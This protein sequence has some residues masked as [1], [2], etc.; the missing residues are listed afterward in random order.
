MNDLQ[1]QDLNARFMKDN[2]FKQLVAN[3]RSRGSLESL[4]FCALVNGRIEI[5]SGHHRVRA[6]KEA[7]LTDIHILLDESGLTRSQVAAKQIAHNA[8]SGQDD[9]GILR[10]LAKII[11]D[12]D[13]M[14]E[15]F[16]GHEIMEKPTA[17][18]DT[19]IAPR[20]DYDW[21]EISFI[22][23]EYQLRDLEKLIKELEGKDLVGAVPME[24]FEKF[25]NALNKYSKFKDI[26][27][28]GSAVHAM[29]ETISKELAV[30][31]FEEDG[32]LQWVPLAKIF[33]TASVPKESAEII[34]E[35]LKK[36]KRDGHVGR[37][38][39][40]QA[41]EYWAADYLG[42]QALSG[43]GPVDSAVEPQKND[44]IDR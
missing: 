6:A 32:E 24:V 8:I 40:W 22:F 23:L 37:K 5:V 15:S 14:L 19:L 7:G 4:P 17:D 13:D 43:T 33:G 10:E 28:V 31:G 27:N 35:G 38:N 30:S 3:I 9:P 2:M 18:L 16:V 44:G 25:A 26:K 1:E 20:V 42:S 36:M 34:K 12:V 41:I 29:A 39:G 21:K 11:T